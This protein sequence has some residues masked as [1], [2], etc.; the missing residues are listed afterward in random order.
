MSG[1][2]LKKSSLYLQIMKCVYTKE[3]KSIAVLIDPGILS[4]ML[5]LIKKC[6]NSLLLLNRK[7]DECKE[8]IRRDSIALK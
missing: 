5:Y 3:G 4:R 2:P 1:L 7:S 6:D 8:S